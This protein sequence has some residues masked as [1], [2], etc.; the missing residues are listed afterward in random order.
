MKVL[1]LCLSL[2][3]SLC[4]TVNTNILDFR[5]RL[6]LPENAFQ[7]YL[8]IF[9]YINIYTYC[10]LFLPAPSEGK[11]VG[12]YQ[13]KSCIE[14]DIV[15]PCVKSPLRVEVSHVTKKV[16]DIYLPWESSHVF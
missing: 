8:C 4:E 11:S 14:F 1:S 13:H 2:V 15:L 6:Y 9:L 16:H 12:E 7:I 10:T 5:L 3:I